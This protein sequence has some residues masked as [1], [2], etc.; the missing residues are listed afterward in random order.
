MEPN[1]NRYRSNE[2]PQDVTV[3]DAIDAAL[4]AL[5]NDLGGYSV[6]VVLTLSACTTTIAA[7][8]GS[9]P[10]NI[11]SHQRR[12]RNVAPGSPNRFDGP[13]LSATLTMK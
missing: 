2:P 8:V 5:K 3:T 12:G 11:P 7:R 1:F 10:V 6:W 9:L 4:C 13:L